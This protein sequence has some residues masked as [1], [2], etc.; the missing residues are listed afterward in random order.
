M[1]QI[2]TKY[3]GHQKDRAGFC[4]QNEYKMVFFLTLSVPYVDDRQHKKYPYSAT[5]RWSSIN[6]NAS[7]AIWTKP[8]KLTEKDNPS[9]PAVDNRR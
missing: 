5:C 1:S 9:V 2:V 7:I 8:Y 6:D 4:E 3:V